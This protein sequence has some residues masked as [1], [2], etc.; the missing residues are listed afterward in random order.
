MKLAL[1]YVDQC[2]VKN[3]GYLIL[4]RTWRLFLSKGV[5]LV[6]EVSNNSFFYIPYYLREQFMKC[7]RFED[8]FHSS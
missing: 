7:K 3:A 5:K 1:G 4:F 2:L 8:I 6:D